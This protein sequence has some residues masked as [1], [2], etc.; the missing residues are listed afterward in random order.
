MSVKHRCVR[1][2]A[3]ATPSSVQHGLKHFVFH[4]LDVR[5]PVLFPCGTPNRAVDEGDTDTA[6]IGPPTVT[7]AGEVEEADP[8]PIEQITVFRQCLAAL[9]QCD[10]LIVKGTNELLQP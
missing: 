7:L 8:F 10:V 1:L 6:V 5:Q 2:T 9:D 3:D 4:H